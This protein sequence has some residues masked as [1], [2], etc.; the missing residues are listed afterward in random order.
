MAGGGV[1][2]AGAYGQR[3]CQIRPKTLPIVG[4]AEAGH[5]AHSGAGGGGGTLPIVGRAEA[6]AV[7]STGSEGVP[8]PARFSSMGGWTVTGISM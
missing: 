6:G 1:Q 7:P 3:N 8:P 2:A 4:R 5:S